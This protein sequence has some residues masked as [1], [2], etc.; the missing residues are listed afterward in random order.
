MPSIGQVLNRR[1]DLST[2]LVHLTKTIEERSALTNLESILDEGRLRAV[3][4]MGWGIR[5]MLITGYDSQKVVCFSEAPLQEINGLLDIEGRQVN[6]EPYGIAFTKMTARKKG[7]NPVWYVD[8]RADHEGQ[9]AEALDA[10][11]K[12]ANAGKAPFTDFAVS[13]IFPF[14][15]EM[16]VSKA[17]NRKEFWWEREWRHVGDFEF[18]PEEVVL[19]LAPEKDHPALA[20]FGRN[21]VDPSWSLERMVASLAGLSEA[22][23][24]P[25]TA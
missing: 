17:G 3:R 18:T 24:T 2:F 19:V 22:A 21:L 5:E 23:V 13:R 11:L 12:R 14:I 6:L 9:I 25:F 20:R 10:L 1:G 4:G 16:G 15:E 7:A 8:T